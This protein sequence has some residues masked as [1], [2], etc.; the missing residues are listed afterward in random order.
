MVDAYSRLITGVYVGIEGGQYA[1]RLLLQN[2]FADK[3]S[4]CRQHNIEIDPQ[5]WPSHHLPT[6]I[7]TDRGSEFLGGPLEIY[8]RA[9]VSKSKICQLTARI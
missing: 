6:K 2:T 9:T 1:L 4:F 3:V 5:D 7:M 8:A